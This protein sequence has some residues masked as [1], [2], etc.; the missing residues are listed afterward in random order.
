MGRFTRIV[1]AL[2][3]AALTVFLSVGVALAATVVHS[4][5]VTVQV[6]EAGP[7]GTHVFVPVPAAAVD[8]GLGIASFALPAEERARIEEQIAPYRPA[9]AAMVRE[10]ER[11]PD[12]TLVDLQSD[13]QTVRVVKRGE[14]FVID[15]DAPDGQVHVAV[16]AHTVSKIAGFLDI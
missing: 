6:H 15:V 16:P 12:A 2:S 11:C 3:V 9:L 14:R 4:G 13:R 10:L 7:Q 5:M 8:L 1:I